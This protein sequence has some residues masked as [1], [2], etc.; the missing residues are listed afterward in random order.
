M[1]PPDEDLPLDLRRQPPRLTP[2]RRRTI[3]KRR[4]AT[5]LIATP[6]AIAGRPARTAG[7]RG[8]LRA[9]TS[10]NKLHDPTTR[11]EREE[12]PSGR[13]NSV[14]HPG[15]QVVGLGRPQASSEARTESAVSQVCSQST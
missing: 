11:L 6:E 8:R 3:N 5:L 10:K 15:L 7:G 14:R 1:L 12:H 9:L 13:L 4:P 2:R